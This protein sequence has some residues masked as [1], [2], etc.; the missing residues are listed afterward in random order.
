MVL[1]PCAKKYSDLKDATFNIDSKNLIAKT[2]SNRVN[3]TIA[4]D[5]DN[6]RYR[7]GYQVSC[8]DTAFSLYPSE[9]D[10][11]AIILRLLNYWL[12]TQGAIRAD[13]YTMAGCFFGL[14]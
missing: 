13:T 1:A 6:I 10:S 8:F 2:Q 4:L 9:L 12:V 5:A 14:V 3:F 11:Y 7:H